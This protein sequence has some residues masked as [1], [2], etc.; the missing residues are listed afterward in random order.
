MLCST[1]E[2]GKKG[3]PFDSAQGRLTGAGPGLARH[4]LARPKVSGVHYSA[5][6]ITNTAGLG[7]DETEHTFRPQPRY[8]GTFLLGRLP[9]EA[10]SD[11]GR[12]SVLGV[13]TGP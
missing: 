4:R 1:K 11:H 5:A 10:F 8:F 13:D 3:L 9:G 6:T 12:L 7:A 2:V